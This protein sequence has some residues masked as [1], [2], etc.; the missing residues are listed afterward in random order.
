MG[1]H[2][3]IQKVFIDFFF[4]LVLQT[5]E[6]KGVESFCVSLSKKV[7]LKFIPSSKKK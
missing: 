7:Y 6:R 4:P 5:K 2:A 1:L 3:H